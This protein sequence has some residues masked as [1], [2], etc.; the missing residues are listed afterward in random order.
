MEKDEILKKL[1]SKLMKEDYQRVLKILKEANSVVGDEL[2]NLLDQLQVNPAHPIKLASLN[3]EL[4]YNFFQ[5]ETAKQTKL[6]AKYLTCLRRSV[7]AI[8]KVRI[9]PETIRGQHVAPLVDLPAIYQGKSSV[10]NVATNNSSQQ[11]SAILMFS[12]TF[13]YWILKK[14]TK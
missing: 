9:F 13:F 6:A 2:E 3:T 5:Q 12:S 11:P 4:D 8:E 7:E 1:S 14:K 10:C